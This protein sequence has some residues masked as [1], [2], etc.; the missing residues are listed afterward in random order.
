MSCF[1]WFDDAPSDPNKISGGNPWPNI[2]LINFL[3]SS[4][5]SSVFFTSL[6]D[7]FVNYLADMNYD[8]PWRYKLVDENNIKDVPPGESQTS[9]ISFR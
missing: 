5:R 9:I 8:D 3:S 6:L 2:V 7:A 4:E 1:S